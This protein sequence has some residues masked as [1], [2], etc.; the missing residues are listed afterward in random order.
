V[1]DAYVF[2]L[3]SILEPKISDTDVSGLWSGGGSSVP[4][5]FDGTLV[6]LLEYV[7]AYFVSLRLH[8]KF[9][10]DCV[11]QVVTRSYEFGLSGAFCIQLLFT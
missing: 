3:G 2:R 11:W 10:P 1:A 7:V 4:L 6:V 5:E 9:D 8:E